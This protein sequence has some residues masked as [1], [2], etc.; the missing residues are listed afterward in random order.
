MDKKTFN[1]AIKARKGRHTEI[2]TPATYYE[3]PGT[4]ENQIWFFNIR[5]K[6]G[7]SNLLFSTEPEI[8]FNVYW[9]Q[10]DMEIKTHKPK[11]YT[12]T[13]EW[14]AGKETMTAEEVIEFLNKRGLIIL[15]EVDNA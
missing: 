7:F 8:K 12:M 4:E 13:G 2:K 6:M 1:Q 3:L 14:G 15:K 11:R 10:P 5:H 9:D